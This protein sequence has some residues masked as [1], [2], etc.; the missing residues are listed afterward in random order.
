MV[1]INHFY[2]HTPPKEDPKRWHLL[3]EHLDAVAKKAREF[4]E[5]FGLGDL[6]YVVGLL[7]DVGKFSKRFQQYL[8]QCHAAQTERTARLRPGMAEHKGAGA[9]WAH[10]KTQPP[11]QGMLALCVLGHHG[12]IPA[13]SNVENEIEERVKRGHAEQAIVN[14]RKVFP[15]VEGA[16]SQIPNDHA[17]D[18]ALSVAENKKLVWEMLTRFLFSCLTDADSLDTEQHQRPDLAEERRAAAKRL[19]AVADSW[20]AT[21]KEDQIR[22]QAQASDTE[23]NRVRREVYE[24]CLEAAKKPPG[25]FSL[26]V[27]TG[28]GKTRSSLAFALAHAAEH[29][30]KLGPRRI[31][32]A[33]P[34]TSIID[35]TAGVFRTIL[36]DEAVLEHHSAIETRP[37][38]RERDSEEDKST[39]QLH[40]LAAENWDAPLIVTTT[41]QLFESL[42]SNRPARCRKLHNIANSIIILD[43]VQTLPLPLLAPLLDGLRILVEHFGVTLLLCT[44]TPPA[45]VGDTPYL[46]GL[47][48]PTP[49]IADPKPSFEILK[50]VTYK[51]EREAWT[52]EQLATHV[53]SRNASCLVVLNTKKDALALL[54]YLR[55]PHTHHLSTLLCSAHRKRILMEVKE[56]LQAE[57]ECGG[58][59][60]VL[61]STQVVEAGVDVDFP[62]VYRAK[63]PLD[64]IIQAAGRANRE[65][66]RDWATC[67]VVIFEPVEGSFPSDGVYKSATALAWNKLLEGQ[68]LDSP[69]VATEYFAQLYKSSGSDALDKKRVQEARNDGDFPA[70]AQKV[71]LIEEDTLPVLVPYQRDE[72]E[73]LEKEIRNLVKR[74]SGMTRELWQRVQPWTVAIYRNDPILSNSLVDWLV[75]DQLLIWRGEYDELTGIGGVIARDPADLVV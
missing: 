42:F 2:A 11:S 50:R 66:L 56:A 8:Q 72:F 31:I 3:T 30:A 47:P 33:I 45:I 17:L 9:K 20:L 55:G 65:G 61:V 75:L 35:Q 15:N 36:G 73:N 70:V 44:A 39:E 53:R 4:A 5:P 58:P 64:R 63:G 25:V 52:W 12:G 41:V 27:P 21:L 69:H 10:D 38:F 68:N 51:I 22:L 16:L 28:G 23:V 57:R 71:R 14:C 43:E 54:E 67:E 29:P 19:Y 49:I 13:C 40:R 37:D 46:K 6:A 34:Y 62:F 26:I 7:H 1:D 60:V 59:P 18:A 32:Y 48:K 74:G 24:A